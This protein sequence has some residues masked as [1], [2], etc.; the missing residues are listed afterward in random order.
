[1][2][3][4]NSKQL[5]LLLLV[6][7]VLFLMLFTQE[8][9]VERDPYLAFLAFV[10]ELDVNYSIPKSNLE[11]IGRTTLE[12]SDF[13]ASLVTTTEFE[14]I[15]VETSQESG[16]I[17]IP[18]EHYYVGSPGYYAYDGMV[19]I[20]GKNGVVTSVFFSPPRMKIMEVNLIEGGLTK[21]ITFSDIQ[22]GDR[23]EIFETLDLVKNNVNDAN[24][25]S[26]SVNVYR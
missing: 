15:V 18:T 16:Q 22:F 26:L 11:W 5:V 13:L 21:P 12:T 24:L 3:K 25:T 7:L 6:A 4:L 9:R 19:T 23:I 1:M 10:D 20:E 8:K 14:G 17:K 2:N